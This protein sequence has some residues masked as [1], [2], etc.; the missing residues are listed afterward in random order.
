MTLISVCEVCMRFVTRRY[1]FKNQW[2]CQECYDRA[3]E[4]LI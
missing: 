1:L 2:M 4:G 3:T